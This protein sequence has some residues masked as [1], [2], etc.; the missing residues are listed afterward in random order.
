MK[1]LIIEDEAA[2]ARRLLRLIDGLVGDYEILDTLD[3]I[4]E[5]LRWFDQNT[6]PD[7]LLLDIH[8][9]DGSSFAIFEHININCPV[10]FVT[11]FDEYAVEAF[12]ANAIDYLLKPIKIAELEQAFGR[13]RALHSDES[14]S[15]LI[16]TLQD[17]GFVRRGK[18]EL[19]KVG[20]TI[21]LINLDTAAYYLSKDK[22]TFAIMPNS[23]RYPVDYSLER[24]NGMLNSKCF[25][26]I[27]RQVIINVS[28]IKCMYS[29]SK[30]R[31]KISLDPPSQDDI[32]VS[33]DRS[34][35]FKKW[36]T[37]SY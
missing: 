13:V 6:P 5:T 2:A 34:P 33:T 30:S 3:S 14:Y 23:K 29:Y 15:E 32:I 35:R 16:Q 9:S 37:S 4:E 21:K 7:V 27:N 22:I 24:L 28:A 10:I 17:S 12:R 18:R 20:Q 31:V 25:F 19:V 1:V 11:A 26:Q 8:L 36:L